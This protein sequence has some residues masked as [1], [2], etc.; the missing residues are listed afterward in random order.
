MKECIVFKAGD[1]Y[2]LARKIDVEGRR[3]VKVD[4]LLKYLPYD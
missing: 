2:S 4:N 1:D 3:A